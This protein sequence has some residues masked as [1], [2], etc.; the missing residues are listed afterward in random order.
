MTLVEDGAVLGSRLLDMGNSGEGLSVFE[1]RDN[2]EPF[3]SISP[4]SE[5]TIYEWATDYTPRDDTTQIEELRN[6]RLSEGISR[7]QAAQ[8]LA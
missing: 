6:I 3:S 5:A 1:T 7:R 2:V 8:E 4:L